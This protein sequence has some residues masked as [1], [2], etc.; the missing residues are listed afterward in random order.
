MMKKVINFLFLLFFPFLI[1]SQPIE[2]VY[3]PLTQQIV[4]IAS[5]KNIMTNSSREIMIRGMGLTGAPYI[6]CSGCPYNFN[7]LLFNKIVKVAYRPFNDFLKPFICS[8]NVMEECNFSPV[9]N[10]VVSKTDSNLIL[11]C[12]LV[13][14]SGFC[15][16]SNFKRIDITT[17]GGISFTSKFNGF[18]SFGG[19][20]IA[21]KNDNI[22]FV[23]T[24]DSLFKSTNR[25]SNWIFMRTFTAANF[26]KFNHY[27]PA[28]VYVSTSGGLQLSTNGGTNFT[29]VFSQ[30]LKDIIFPDSLTIFGFTNNSVYNS[31]NSGLNWNSLFTSANWNLNCLDADP[32]NNS[33]IHAGS[34]NGLWRSTNGGLNFSKYFNA[35]PATANVL[36]IL[37]DPSLGDTIYAVTPKGI[38]RVWG[39]L[40]SIQNISTKIPGNF[41]IT[42]I[43]PNP[44]NPETT[45]KF[46]LNNND[47][48]SLVILDVTGKE[49]LNLIS[50]YLQAG[51]YAYNLNAESL[52]SG[53]Y[54]CVLKSGSKKSIKKI[55]LFK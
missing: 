33:V 2:Q 26:V 13:S 5:S 45:I 19:F 3:N 1:Y 29:N 36:N 32:S 11:R 12:F 54:F 28:V 25:G 53:I 55:I 10:Y 34:T 41:E 9:D 22:M 31:T 44:F 20:D 49:I 14:F 40:V 8:D 48:I 27:N 24:G 4:S 46:T 47:N 6:C 38:F 43:Y 39:T 51:E 18:S 17:N 15:Q 50:G 42:N 16:S 52:S 21:Q 30:N 37:K 35:F 7:N 23:I